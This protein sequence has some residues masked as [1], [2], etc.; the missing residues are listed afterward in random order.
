MIRRTMLQI[1]LLGLAFALATAL[2]GWWAVPALGCL[3]GAY[4]RAHSRPALVAALAA[5]FGWLLL[6]GWNAVSGPLLLLAKRA[7]GVLG[8]PSLTL[9][10]LTLLY[11]MALAW[12]AGIVGETAKRLFDSRHRK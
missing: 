6:L 11:P 12:G 2:F 8:V 4:E 1:G 10:A 3:W 9:I 5:G 7:S